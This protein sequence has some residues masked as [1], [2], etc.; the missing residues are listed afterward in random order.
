MENELTKFPVPPSPWVSTYKTPAGRY[1][2]LPQLSK[3]K[4]RANTP[5]SATAPLNFLD[6]YSLFS[7]ES[8]SPRFS[9]IGVVNRFPST[10]ASLP[11][12]PE[13][14]ACG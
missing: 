9:P 13:I 11:T 8:P 7:E 1:E 12:V 6:I 14:E 5:A 4:L 10:G 3:H 2:E